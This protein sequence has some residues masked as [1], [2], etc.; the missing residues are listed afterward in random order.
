MKKNQQRIP[1]FVI[2]NSLGLDI[3]VFVRVS[4]RAKKI[5]IGV[6]Y[7]GP[8]LVL[9]HKDCF[10]IGYKCLLFKEDW[11][12]KKFKDFSLHEPID[13]NTIPI[14]G[15]TYTILRIDSDECR[16]KVDGN[17][18]QVYSPPVQH[19]NTLIIFL[20]D[21]VMSKIS[22]FALALRK[23]YQFHFIM[24]TL[25]NNKKA[26]GYCSGAAVLSFNWRLVFYPPEI[27]KYIV[28]H[29]MCH[30]VEKG[31]SQRF[32]NLVATIYPDYLSAELWLKQNGCRLYRYLSE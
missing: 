31:H 4:V 5:F 9:P 11:I 1:S 19:N 29:E 20:Q 10:D 23:Q 21:K 24:I 26:W 8:E 6:G 15:E 16:V 25:M 30:L 18:I 12:R 2:L 32:W 7:K 17:V 27:L 3:K 28:V 14:F 13:N 22:N